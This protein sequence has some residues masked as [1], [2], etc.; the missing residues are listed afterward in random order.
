M[1]W[2]LACALL[3]GG[4][5]MAATSADL[6]AAARAA[7][8]CGVIGATIG[9]P[10]NQATWSLQFDNTVT[11]NQQSLAQAALTA[12]N[13]NAASVPQS[14]S[15]LQAKVAL[16]RAGLLPSVQTWVGTQSTE[17]QLMWNS[18]TSYSRTSTLINSAAA[19]L[20]ISQS[21][22][23]QLFITAATIAP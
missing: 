3:F 17:I 5:A 23:D 14:V 2:I 7:C 4:P 9:D 15:A 21:Q 10:S 6:L 18:A 1:H 22:L 16:S 20:G 19:A 12:F 13:A 11:G 8:S